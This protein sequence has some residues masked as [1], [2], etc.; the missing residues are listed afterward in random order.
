[1][2]PLNAPLVLFADVVPTVVKSEAVGL[3]DR[4]HWCSGTTTQ[5]YQLTSP[6][7]FS[8]AV[9]ASSAVQTGATEAFTTIQLDP[10]IDQ[11]SENH[12]N[13][14]GGSTKQHGVWQQL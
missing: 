9:S 13:G 3:V 6:S 14:D 5:H 8:G 1:M 4:H 11:S 10:V 7:L 2:T 12:L